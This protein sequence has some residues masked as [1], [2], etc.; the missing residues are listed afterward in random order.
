[1]ERM[2]YSPDFEQAWKAYGRVPNQS[3]VMAAANW[4]KL[5]KSNMLP[6]ESA[7]LGAISSYRSW[8]ADV[9]RRQG[10]PFPQCH[11]ATWLSPRQRKFEEWIPPQSPSEAPTAQ[12]V[13]SWPQDIQDRICQY[14][15]A[16][17]LFR[18][19]FAPATFF[20]GP[21]P[22]IQAPSK[23]CQTF[24]ETKFRRA[25]DKAISPDVRITVS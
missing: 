19:W 12:F 8:L 11:M 1:M 3:K 24:L 23:L 18:A 17:E 4:D 14:G 9:S 21:P 7:M 2:T 5:K 22:T 6:D 15:V 13:S 25:I 16:A 20:P 10:R